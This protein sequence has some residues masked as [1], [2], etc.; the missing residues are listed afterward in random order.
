LLGLYSLVTLLARQ[1]RKMNQLPVRTSACYA[2]ENATFS[3]TLALV[4]R[5]LWHEGYFPMS[6]TQ[7]EMLK[8]PRALLEHLTNT[9]CYA[10]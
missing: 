6:N 10:A 7:A 2:K 1:M 3:D 4:R 8:I 5:Q 9:L